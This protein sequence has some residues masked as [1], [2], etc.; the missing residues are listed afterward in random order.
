MIVVR[1]TNNCRLTGSDHRQ[2][3]AREE[4]AIRRREGAQEGRERAEDDAGD[5]G[6]TGEVQARPGGERQEVSGDD[7]MT[8]KRTL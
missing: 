6:R 4:D 7:A 1:R 8:L 2:P 5:G 3:G